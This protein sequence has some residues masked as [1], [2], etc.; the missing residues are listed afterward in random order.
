VSVR[1]G[2]INP[3]PRPVDADVHV[4]A[5]RAGVEVLSNPRLTIEPAQARNYAAL[6]VRGADEVERMRSK[7]ESP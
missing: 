2:E 4:A 6:L 3:D 1:I 7:P 5:S